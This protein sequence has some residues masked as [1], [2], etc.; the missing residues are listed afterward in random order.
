MNAA[1]KRGMLLRH[2]GHVY[3]VEDVS[4]RH[5]GKMKP[6]FHVALRDAV[7]GRH[8]ERA[9]DDL[10]PVEE[11]AGTY[12]PMQY[13][14]ARGEERMF[15]DAQTFEEQDLGEAVRRDGLDPFL[16]EGDEFRVLFAG[17][18]P[19]RVQVPDSVTLRVADTAAP[20]HAVGTGGGGVLKEARLE[21]GLEV[22][23]PLFI[24]PGD[25]VRVDTRSREYLG[26]ATEAG[27]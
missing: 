4:E 22:R 18:R 26:K 20:S 19:L 8:I 7:D 10:L 11:V 5:S 1:V 12:R 9:M 21:N 25:L 27:R 24:K 17:E 2:Q 3:F 16:K 14:Y 6:T 15:M 13:L 23:V